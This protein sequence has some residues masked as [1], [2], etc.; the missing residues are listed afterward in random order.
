MCEAQYSADLGQRL[1][2]LLVLWYSVIVDV[3]CN[4]RTEHN[5]HSTRGLEVARCDL[6]AEGCDFGGRLIEPKQKVVAIR[7]PGNTRSTNPAVE[8]LLVL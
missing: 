2:S 3:A 5:S 8:I 4:S 7:K 1:V 6:H